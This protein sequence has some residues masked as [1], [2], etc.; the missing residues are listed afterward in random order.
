[1]TSHDWEWFIAPL[2]MTGGWFTLVLTTWLLFISE[3]HTQTWSESPVSETCESTTWSSL[4]DANQQ[5]NTSSWCLQKYPR[6]IVELFLVWL[7]CPHGQFY[8]ILEC[9][10]KPFQNSQDLDVQALEE[11]PIVLGNDELRFLSPE[12]LR[13]CGR[14]ASPGWWTWTGS[15]PWSS[16]VHKETT[17]SGWKILEDWDL[18]D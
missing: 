11:A 5:K 6:V 16:M 15:G 18:K 4:V 1:M 13:V 8:W 12:T 3:S 2:V 17:E 9:L 14:Y 7:W 10:T